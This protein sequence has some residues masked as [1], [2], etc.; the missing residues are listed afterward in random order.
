MFPNVDRKSKSSAEDPQKQIAEN[1]SRMVELM[2]SMTRS[3]E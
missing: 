1:T 3:N 2:L